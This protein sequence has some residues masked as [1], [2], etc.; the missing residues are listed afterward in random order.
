MLKGVT[1]IRS[2]STQKPTDLSTHFDEELDVILVVELGDVLAGGGGRPEQRH[3]LVQVVVQDE[4]V[5]YRQSVW[6]HRMAWPVMVGTHLGR[7][8]IC[9]IVSKPTIQPTN[10]P[11][12]H[13]SS[14]H[15]CCS[16]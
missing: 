8:G 13:R 16:S 6:F 12:D 4:G 10:L 7:E 2:L 11:L 3:L 5:S 1:W 9:W 15:F 14:K